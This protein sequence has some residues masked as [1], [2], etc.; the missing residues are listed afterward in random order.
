MAE[1]SMFIAEV[2][3]VQIVIIIIAMGAGFIQWLWGLIQQ[4]RAARERQSQDLEDEEMARLR[5]EAWKRQTG[6]SPTPPRPSR[7][8]PPPVSEEENP[9]TV[10]REM[11]EKAQEATKPPPPPVRPTSPPPL[12]AQPVAPAPAPVV[13]RQV[14]SPAPAPATR[15]A[16]EAKAAKSAPPAPRAAPAAKLAPSSTT[17]KSRARTS[18]LAALLARPEALRQA[19]ILRE[20]LG[21]PK[22]LQSFSDAP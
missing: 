15:Q 2:D 8:A 4:G 3:P 6:E 21:P 7:H 18:D 20:V 9:W 16:K 5:E 10:I 11:L 13:Q 1:C 17:E 22:A 12:P 19:V 14:P